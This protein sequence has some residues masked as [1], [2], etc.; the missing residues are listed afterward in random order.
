LA[1]L[2]AFRLELEASGFSLRL[3]G[4]YI[5]PLTGLPDRRALRRVRPGQALLFVDLDDFKAVNAQYG[6]P[7]GDAVLA[8][9]GERLRGWRERGEAVVRHGGDEFVAVVPSAG[10]ERRAE[11]LLEALREPVP[12]EAGTVRCSATAGVAVVK[13]GEAL[14][15]LLRRADTGLRRAKGDTSGLRLIR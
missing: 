11:S 14:S 7:A 4:P 8:A 12:T 1:G 13:P 15:D 9:M 6:H 3:H 10:V 5:D 2:L